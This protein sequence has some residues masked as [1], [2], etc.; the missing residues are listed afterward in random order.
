MIGW[1]KLH[2]SLVEWEWYD[3]KNALILL[4]HLLVTVNY[5]DK[6]W[7]GIL[8]KSGS[9]V[10]SW[11]T[12][13]NEINCMSIQQIR[14]AMDKLEFSGEI[15]RSS[16]NKYQVVSLVKWGKLQHLEMLDNN[17]SNTLITNKQQTNN[18][19][20]T[21]TKEYKEIKEVNKK[22]NNIYSVEVVEYSFDDF[23][24]IYPNKTNKKKAQEKFNKLTKG[25]KEKIEQH[26]PIFINNPPFKDYTYPHA[27]TYLNQERFNDEIQLNTINLKSLNNE[28]FNKFTDAIRQQY[29]D[30]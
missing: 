14:T 6:K 9:R 5:E 19:Q 3:D 7:K 21:T 13:K 26:L 22:E 28:Q 2:R 11:E 24:S 1:I 23:W 25:Q 30:A 20:I 12:L 15:T 17:Q 29:P 8:I 18:N 27:V 4:I 16:T 10:T